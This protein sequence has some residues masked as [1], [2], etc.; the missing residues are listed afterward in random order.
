MELKE[1]SKIGN[2]DKDTNYLKSN[3]MNSK[4]NGAEYVN[5]MY[6]KEF[7]NK[8]I[9]NLAGIY[10]PNI[11]LKDWVGDWVGRDAVLM[12][13]KKFFKNDFT[14]TVE[15]S[16]VGFDND[17][18]LIKIKNDIVIEINGETIKAVDDILFN[19][20]DNKIYSITAY[21]R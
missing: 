14:I 21:K 11:V 12:E 10:S 20:N 3:N 7:N 5:K 6:F 2:Q 19:K 8:Q 17:M 16:V 9:G 4:F 13:N 15:N 1:H 18:K